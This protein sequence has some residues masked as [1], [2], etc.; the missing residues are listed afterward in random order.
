MKPVDYVPILNAYYQGQGFPPF[1]W[2]IFEDSPWTPLKKPLKECNV[3]LHTSGGVTRKDQNPFHP[4]AFN[5]LSFRIIPVDTP[6]N[7]LIISDLYY[8][9]DNADRDI[10]IIFPLERFRELKTEAYFKKFSLAVS[11]PN[12]RIYRRTALIQ[13]AVPRMVARLKEAEV[14][15]FIL[16]PC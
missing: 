2:S 6:V 1:Q 5:D 13:E 10:N 16:S 4:L 9:H 14:D 7:E 15:I 12:G 8:D 11:G 3:A